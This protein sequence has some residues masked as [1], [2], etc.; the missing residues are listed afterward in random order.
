MKVRKNEN[1]KRIMLEGKKEVGV[2]VMIEGEIKRILEESEVIIQG[3][4]I[5]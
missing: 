1:V 3:G 5:K 2:E 4:Q